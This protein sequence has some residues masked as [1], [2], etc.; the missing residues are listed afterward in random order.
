LTITKTESAIITEL[1]NQ[2]HRE[3]KEMVAAMDRAKGKA[4][5]LLMPTIM[6]FATPMKYFKKNKFFW[7]FRMKISSVQLKN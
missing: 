6:G 7:N 1:A 4:K 2:P 3:E 5:T